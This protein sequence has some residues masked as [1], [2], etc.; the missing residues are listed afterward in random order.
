[1]EKKQLK[2]YQIGLHGKGR[3]GFERLVE[4]SKHYGPVDVEVVGVYDRD[5]ER[6]ERAKKF[7]KVNG[8][9][10]DTFQEIDEM[11]RDA[12]KQG[13]R[14]MVY[15]AGSAESRPQNLHSSVE[16]G[17]FHLA[18]KPPSMSREEHLKEK[19]LAEG[20]KAMWKVDFIERENP[21]VKKAL[22]ELEGK[23]IE[24]IEVYRQSS[25]GIEKMLDPGSRINL[26][27][28]DVLDKMINEVFVLDF[29]EVSENGSPGLQLEEA[30]TEYYL[31]HE[32]GS[33]KLTSLHGSRTSNPE[34]ASTAMTTAELSSEKVDVKLSSSWMGLTDGCMLKAKDIKDQ[35]G[36]KVYKREFS[37][38]EG[39]SYVNEEA[40][41]F[42]VEGEKEIVGDMLN[43]KLYDIQEG[44]EIEVEKGLHD[45]LYRVLE[46]AVNLAVGAEDVES[47][48]MERDVFM[49]S[50]FDILDSVDSES[51]VDEASKA[52]EK[53]ESL[54]VK[55][56]KLKEPDTDDRVAG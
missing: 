40:S 53:A 25:F 22:E 38:L 23:E 50:L 45:Q 8:K 28:G 27:G 2:V 1:M 26:R 36:C 47:F 42:V 33:E 20:G 35:I 21:V 46:Q 17:F 15:D 32:L 55:G 7:A 11:Y 29:L 39:D 34:K 48:E 3:Y 30:W 56:G 31:P 41:F 24:S 16:R 5:F 14:V 13:S 54:I 37:E 43:G 6:L 44:E 4:I 52:S 9:N 10:I 18:E 19:E 51:A 49:E 12:E